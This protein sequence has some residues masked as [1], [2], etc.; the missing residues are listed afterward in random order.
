MEG[1]RG[2]RS[3]TKS[4]E[5]QRNADPCLRLLLHRFCGRCCGNAA[6][7]GAAVVR[8]PVDHAIGVVAH[9]QCSV[10]GDSQP[11]RPREMR[12][13]AI[14]QKAGHERLYA[15]GFPDSKWMRATS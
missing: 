15:A 10:L 3:C 7:S 13:T 2:A 5:G 12:L 9:E 14:G 11:H 1:E 4:F 8:N 6:G